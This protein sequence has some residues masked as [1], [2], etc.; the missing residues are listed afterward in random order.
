MKINKEITVGILLTFLL[1]LL[2]SC[3]HNK[4]VRHQAGN[5][6]TLNAVFSKA[7]GLL[8][9]SEVRLAGIQVGKM[10]NQ[11]L[12]SNGYQVVVQLVFD[13][14]MDIPIDSSV[15]IE[16][17]GIMGAKHIE[18]VPGGDEELMQSGDTFSYTQDALILN[19]L[20]DKVNAF[21]KEK[22]EKETKEKSEYTESMEVL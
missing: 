6:F 4:S 17:D 11:T 20:L 19:E 22:K 21:M 12:A 18:I 13:K 16:T 5:H 9:S 7:D 8:P 2:L 1:G 10:G 14:P 15:S 3:V